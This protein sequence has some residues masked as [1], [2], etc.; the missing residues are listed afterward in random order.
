MNKYY[1]TIALCII[2][3]ILYSDK[4]LGLKK[5]FIRPP[6]TNTSTSL[7]HNSLKPFLNKKLAKN[8]LK[9]INGQTIFVNEL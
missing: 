9:S 2:F 4:I 6:S 7:S 8:E 1:I 5:L 3:I